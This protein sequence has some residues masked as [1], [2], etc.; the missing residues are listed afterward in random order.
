M[1]L[2]FSR[3]GAGPEGGISNKFL[4][5]AVAMGQPLRSEAVGD[6]QA[7]SPHLFAQGKASEAFFRS[8]L[9]GLEGHHADPAAVLEKG[10]P[11]PLPTS[12]RHHCSLNNQMEDGLHTQES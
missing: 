2:L 3:A 8:L 4:G 6:L 10:L 5:D 1:W 12:T 7:G 9:Q 11:T